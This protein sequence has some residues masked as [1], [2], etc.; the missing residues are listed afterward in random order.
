MFAITGAVPEF[1]AEKDAIFPVPE[2]AN[3]ILGVSFVHV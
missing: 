1:I 3:P 2:A